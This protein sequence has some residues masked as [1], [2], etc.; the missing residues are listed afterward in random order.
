ML[1]PATG[2][3]I[4]RRSCARHVPALCVLAHEAQHHTYLEMSH[5]DLL[6]A[7]RTMEASGIHT[8]RLVALGRRLRVVKFHWKPRLGVHSVAE[9]AQLINGADPDF[10]PRDLA[11]AIRRA[12]RSGSWASRSSRTRSRASRASTC[13]IPHEDR[14]GGTGSRGARGPHDPA[15]TP[16]IIRADGAGGVQP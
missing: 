12:S 4:P 15:G 7:V 8:F 5:W 9:E 11:D 14:A 13:S 2:P 3:R 10:P 1:E 6:F 16:P